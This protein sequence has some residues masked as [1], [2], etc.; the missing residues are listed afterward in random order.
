[1]S[2]PKPKPLLCRIGLHRWRYEAH[3]K[4]YGDIRMYAAFDILDRCTRCGKYS[5]RLAKELPDAA[6]SHALGRGE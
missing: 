1:M 3:Y 5:Q 6:I 4:L 2:G